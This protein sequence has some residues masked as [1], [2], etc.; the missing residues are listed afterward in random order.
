[1]RLRHSTYALL[2]VC[3]LA[4]QVRSESDEFPSKTIDIGVVVSDVE[5]AVKFYTESIGFTEVEGFT[6]PGGFATDAGLTDR[7]PLRIRVVVL[8]DEE[9]ATKLKLM[10]LPGVKSK[11]GDHEF[12]YSQLGVSYITVF[13]KDTTAAL[14]RL[15]S[16]GVQPIAKGPV[17]LP[18]PLPEGV[19]LT[20]VRDPD[21]NIIELVGPKSS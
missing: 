17:A 2:I 16:T 5:K 6:M 7:Q 21:G 13:V 8:G 4:S 3:V 9:G 1:M 18:K 15:K 19:F 11:K 10:Q 20:L 14:K 12:I